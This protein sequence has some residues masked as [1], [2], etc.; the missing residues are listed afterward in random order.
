MNKCFEAGGKR[1]RPLIAGKVLKVMAGE[2]GEA[3]AGA[4]REPLV[5]VGNRLYSVAEA[6]SPLGR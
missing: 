1:S 6:I 4:C 2:G 3:F 5:G